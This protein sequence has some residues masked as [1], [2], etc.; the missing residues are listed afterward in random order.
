MQ[1]IPGEVVPIRVKPSEPLDAHIVDGRQIAED[2]VDEFWLSGTVAIDECAHSFS[3][4][5]PAVGRDE[6]VGYVPRCRISGI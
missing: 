6:R 3:V 5:S 2:Q 1:P 4:L